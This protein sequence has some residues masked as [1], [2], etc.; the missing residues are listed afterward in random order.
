MSNALADLQRIHDHLQSQ[1]FSSQFM[2]SMIEYRLKKKPEVSICIQ[3]KE[4]PYR[5]PHAHGLLLYRVLNSSFLQP[6]EIKEHAQGIVWQ[7]VQDGFSLEQSMDVSDLKSAI[8]PATRKELQRVFSKHESTREAFKA[9]LHD[10]HA[11]LLNGKAGGHGVLL[12][13]VK[14]KK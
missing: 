14:G 11:F 2:G 9:M 4:H 7:M 13:P 12:A 1:G 6:D 8:Q 10:V 5:K 3:I